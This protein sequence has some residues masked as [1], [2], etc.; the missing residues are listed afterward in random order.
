[1]DFQ[2][3]QWTAENMS[4]SQHCHMVM[5]EN[6]NWNVVFKDICFVLAAYWHAHLCVIVQSYVILSSYTVDR[7]NRSI[8]ESQCSYAVEQK[9]LICRD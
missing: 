3:Y 9:P 5:S 7:L 1:M 2:I 8:I 4:S 6:I